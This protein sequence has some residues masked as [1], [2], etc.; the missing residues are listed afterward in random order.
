MTFI[1][2]EAYMVTT[3]IKKT[4]DPTY[5]EKAS[6]D[7]RLKALHY[8]IKYPVGDPHD[9]FIHLGEIGTEE[10]LY[11]LEKRAKSYRIKNETLCTAS[12]CFEAIKEIKKRIEKDSILKK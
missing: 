5:M 11:Y 6:L 4:Y 7:D 10:S 3:S 12:H 2:Y 8:A 1:G 9:A